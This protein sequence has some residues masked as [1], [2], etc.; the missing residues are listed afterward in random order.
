MQVHLACSCG[1]WVAVNEGMAGLSLRCACGGTVP[2][3]PL[4][5]LRALAEDDPQAGGRRAAPRPPGFADR[6]ITGV[7][8]LALVVALLVLA[9]PGLALGGPLGAAG[10][11][12]LIVGWGWLLLRIAEGRPL[13]ALF[14][15]LRPWL[16]VRFA[17]DHWQV[18]RWPFLC[19]AAGLV[20]LLLGLMGGG[21]R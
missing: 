16:L 20:L 21:L 2:V 10:V 9:V 6:V 11:P 13:A 18:A 14:A 1:R 3:P 8:G 17:I 5:E 7:I 19:Y 4:R 12:L 15:V